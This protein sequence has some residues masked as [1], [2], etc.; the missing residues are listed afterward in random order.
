MAQDKLVY[1]TGQ[2]SLRKTKGEPKTRLSST[3]P[4]KMRLETKGR[5][6]KAVTVLWNF[7]FAEVEVKALVKALQQKSACGATIK[8]GRAEFQGDIRVQATTY[9]KEQ[10]WTLV[11]AGG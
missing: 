4:T 6:G 9:F 3:G 7:P 5:G 1:T 8:A 11:P 10:G 2:G